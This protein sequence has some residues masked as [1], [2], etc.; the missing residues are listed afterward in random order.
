[1]ANRS[2]SMIDSFPVELKEAVHQAILRGVKYEDITAMINE[3]GVN[4][5]YK[6]VAKYGKKFTAKLESIT[7]AK[8]QAKS[9]IETSAGLKLDL[10]EATTMASLQLLFDMLINTE[11]DQ[12]DKNTISAIKAAA[13]LERSAVS[14]EKL[15]FSYEKGVTEA[16]ESIKEALRTEVTDDEEL[17]CR[18]TEIVDKAV[19]KMQDNI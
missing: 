3:A 9:I 11:S 17:L 8:E 13:S 12:L 14:R 19:D 2:H 7:R 5:S 10:A 18:L 15:K 16:K 6:T 4:I 1:M